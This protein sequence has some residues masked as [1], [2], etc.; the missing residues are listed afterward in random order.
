[1]KTSIRRV[2]GECYFGVEITP[3]GRLVVAA[4]VNGKP[5]PAEHFPS[6]AAG[7]RELG[8]RIER[9]GAHPHVCIQACGAAALGLA[10]ALIPVRGVEV[11]LVSAQA[12]QITASTTSEERAERLAR[13]AERLF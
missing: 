4:R 9:E 5:A 12:I 2:D 6:G 7:A 1:M 10:A 8:E 13:L 3:D 11:T